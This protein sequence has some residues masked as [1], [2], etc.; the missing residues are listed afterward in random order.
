MSEQN[1]LTVREAA[2]KYPMFPENTLR[3]MIS[4]PDNYF[5]F[6][7]VFSR[8]GRKIV[9]FDDMFKAWIEKDKIRDVFQLIPNDRRSLEHVDVWYMRGIFIEIKE[10][11]GMDKIH[12]I[13][14]DDK[15]KYT[16]TFQEYSSEID[17]DQDPFD[18]SLHID[19]LQHPVDI[20]AIVN[21][22]ESTEDIKVKICEHTRK[23]LEKA[24]DL[25]HSDHIY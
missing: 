19:F 23:F 17:D 10:T 5:G 9:I 14:E 12:V 20:N 6:S 22:T 7:N 24:I 13:E 25:N 16:C 15:G 3:Y 4:H 8:I 1:Y 21:S 2:A 18:F 11:F